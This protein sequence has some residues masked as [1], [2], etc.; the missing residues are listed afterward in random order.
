MDVLEKPTEAATDIHMTLTPRVVS[1]NDVMHIE[2]LSKSFG[3][4]QL[5]SDIDMDLKRGEHSAASSCSK[6]WTSKSS[7]G[8]MWPSSATT[9][10]EKPPS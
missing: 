7:G 8:S 4:R 3:S 6:M 5:F 9:A 10:P 2:G 1:G